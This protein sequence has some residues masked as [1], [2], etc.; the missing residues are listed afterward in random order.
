MKILRW[1]YGVSRMVGINNSYAGGN[2]IEERPKETTWSHYASEHRVFG[3][4]VRCK[5]DRGETEKGLEGGATQDVSGRVHY[6]APSQRE[7]V[8]F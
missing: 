1:T 5:R 6:H 2:V 7:L 8:C 4:E 3:L